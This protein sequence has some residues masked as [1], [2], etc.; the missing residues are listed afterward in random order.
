MKNTSDTKLTYTA[1]EGMQRLAQGP[2][3]AVV[4]EVRRRSREHKEASILVFNDASGT[5]MDFDLSGSEKEVLKRLQVFVAPPEAT[6]A[7]TG[8]GRP[9][10]GVVAREVSLLPR[11]W[12]WLATQ[13]GGASAAIRRLVED[14]RKTGSGPSQVKASQ[15]RTYRF[16]AALAGNLPNYEEAL[17]AL[18]KRD[19]S[20]FR[21]HMKGWPADIKAHALE[22]G[23]EVF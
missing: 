12:E 6:P 13:P 7:A 16:L 11:H 20:K 3:E 10:L 9:R 17:R 5:T 19:E 8:P 14:A 22:L 18:Y 2:L 1:F 23:A 21:E 15:E 4:L